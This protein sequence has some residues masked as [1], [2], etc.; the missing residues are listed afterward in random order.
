MHLRSR[1]FDPDRDTDHGVGQT[2]VEQR[3]AH[4]PVL[5]DRPDLAH[6]LER[7]NFKVIDTAIHTVS[8][9]SEG[10]ICAVLQLA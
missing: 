9:L 3:K 1:A 4:Q 5:Q 6:R 8:R 2:R 10:G 7:T